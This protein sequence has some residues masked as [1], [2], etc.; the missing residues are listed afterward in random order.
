MHAPSEPTHHGVHV[1]AVG[2]P[3]LPPVVLVHGSPGSM[4]NWLDLITQTDV[5]AHA[6]LIA[7]DRPGFGESQPGQ[8]VSSLQAQATAIQQA[9]LPQ[10]AGRPALWL[11][12]SFGGPVIA[13]MAIDFPH[14]VAG[15]ILLR[16]RSIQL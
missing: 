11:G 7:V 6:Y 1:L 2:D 16:L 9:V 3:Q 14:S 13:R 12:H 4:D 8:H 10:L 5:L 15:L